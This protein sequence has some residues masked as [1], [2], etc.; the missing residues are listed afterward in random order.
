MSLK[1]FFAYAKIVIAGVYL[2]LAVMLFFSN[3][4][5]KC[6]NPQLFTTTFNNVSLAKLMLICVLVGAAGVLMI[7]MLFSGGRALYKY[8]KAHPIIKPQRAMPEYQN[9]NQNENLS[10]KE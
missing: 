5:N 9:Q 10:E 7:W 6:D 4:G 8:R 1:V 3:A 2:L